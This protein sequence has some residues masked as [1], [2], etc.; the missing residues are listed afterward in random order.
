MSWGLLQ[1]RSVWQSS[2]LITLAILFVIII[3]FKLINYIYPSWHNMLNCRLWLAITS[4]TFI[5]WILLS[6]GFNWDKFRVKV[7]F[8]GIFI[9]VIFMLGI[10]VIALCTLNGD[11]NNNSLLFDLESMLSIALVICCIVS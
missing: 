8:G 2:L 3:A 9:F 6:V 11:I 10:A 5:I 7:N 1:I 4:I